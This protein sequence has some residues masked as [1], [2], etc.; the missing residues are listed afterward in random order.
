MWIG[1]G[2]QLGDQWHQAEEWQGVIEKV[3]LGPW[4]RFG[5]W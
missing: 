3:V 1:V 5:G 2:R 4:C